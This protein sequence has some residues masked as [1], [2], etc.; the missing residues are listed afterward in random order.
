[1]ADATGT[2]TYTYD[3]A[4]RLTGVTA[5]GTGTVGYTYDAAGERTALTYPSGH[6]VQFAYTGRGQLQSVTD[7]NAKQTAYSYDSAGRLTGIAS[8]NGVAGTLGYDNADRLTSL[9][10]AKGGTSLESI[11]YTLDAAGNRTAMTDSTGATSYG[12]DAL[13]RLTGASYPNG[14]SVAYAYDAV[15]NRTGLTVNGATTTSAFDAADRL[16]QAGGTSYTYDANGNQLTKAAGGITTTYT[17][18]LL[19]RLIGI[20][21][22]ATASYAYNGDGL[23]V[24]KTVGG[25]TT[26][27]AWDPTGLGTVL[28]D[29]GEYVWGQG[30]VGQVTGSGTTYAHSDGLGS[31]RLLTDANGNVAGRQQ[32]DAYG[33]SRSQSG[34]QL[35]FGFTGEQQDPESGLV[36]LRARYYDP[37]TGRFLSKDP[38]GL[39]GGSTDLY[40]YAGGDPVRYADP[41][42]KDFVDMLI[43]IYVHP[44]IEAEFRQQNP[45]LDAEQTFTIGAG[46]SRTTVKLDLYN[47]ATNEF[48][49]VEPSGGRD[50]GVRQV[51]RYQGL[52]FRPSTVPFSP[53]LI[54]TV[55]PGLSIRAYMDPQ[56]QAGLILYDRVWTA[57]PPPSTVLI[58]FLWGLLGW[59][60][61]RTPAP[62]PDP[63]P[64]IVSPCGDANV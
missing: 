5:P 44:L 11:A 25:T 15:G 47:Y 50:T 63:Q 27:Y 40:P 10:Y 6:Q 64:S 51:R 48:H 52:G 45:G 9:A 13:G 4:D 23:R 34:A 17:Y 2:T 33:A 8:P 56:R 46:R 28:S 38:L 18:D 31:I 58:P 49:E 16:T 19:N 30:L 37:A 35:P 39:G 42:G 59:N 3:S 12:Y 61:A 29:G 54:P 22:P 41:S 53:V 20:S 14:D 24:G 21:G 62:A 55:V 60:A 32:F 43:G 36:Y 26:S 1:M 7:W 57:P